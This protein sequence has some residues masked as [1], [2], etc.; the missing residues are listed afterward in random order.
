MMIDQ[1]IPIVAPL[2]LELRKTGSSGKEVYRVRATVLN[3]NLTPVDDAKVWSSMGGEAK[4][5]AGGW[6]FDIPAI[7]KPLDGKLTVFASIPNAFLSGQHEIRLREDFNPSITVKL[8][9]DT[10]AT[11]RGMIVDDHGRAVADARVSIVGYGAEG[12]TT[13]QGGSFILPAHSAADESV[14]LHAEKKGYEP[15]NQWHPAGDEAVTI[16]LSRSK[17]DVKPES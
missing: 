2:Y 9:K 15:I 12:I 17:R 14:Q 16:V 5:V 3:S 10:S 6:Q 8:T 13:K 1:V 11:V 7:S 4:K